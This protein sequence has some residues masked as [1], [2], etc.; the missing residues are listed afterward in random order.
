[1]PRIPKQPP[2]PAEEQKH[3]RGF[4]INKPLSEATTKDFSFIHRTDRA[5]ANRSGSFEHLSDNISARPG[6]TRSVYDAYRPA[7]ATPQF[8]RETF[9]KCDLIYKKVGLIKNI[10]D[11]YSDF[12]SQGIRVCHPVPKIQRIGRTWFK[13]VKGKER[14]ERFLNY[15]YRQGNTVIRIHTGKV[16]SSIINKMSKITAEDDGEVIEMPKRERNVI[17][18]DYTF[19]NPA[20]VEPVGGNLAAFSGNKRYILNIPPMITSSVPVSKEIEAEFLAGLSDEMKVLVKKGGY[21][22]LPP[23]R[24]RVYSYKK[25]DWEAWA[26]PITYSVFDNV[27][28][29]EKLRLADNAALDGLISQLR[30]FKLGDRA[31]RVAPTQ[32]AAN[33]LDSMLQTNVGGGTKEIIWGPDI[34]V[35][36]SNTDIHNFLGSEK[37]K[38]TLSAIFQAFGIPPTLT[39]DFGA[40]GTTNNYISLKACI[41]RIKY[42]RDILVSF[43]EEQLEWLRKSLGLAKPFTIEFDILNLVDDIAEKNLYLQLVDRNIVSAEVLQYLFNQ[44]PEMENVRLK[45]E[46]KGRKNH[47]LV[48]KASPLSSPED[49]RTEIALQQGSISPTEADL[50]PAEKTDKSLLDIQAQNAKLKTTQGGNPPKTKKRPGQG[51]P[52]NKQDSTKRKTRTFTA[53]LIPWLSQTQEKVTSIVSGMMLK[54]TGKKNLRCLT[55]EEKEKCEQ[56]SFLTLMAIPPDGVVDDAVVENALSGDFNM[57]ALASYEEQVKQYSVVNSKEPTVEEQRLIQLGVYLRY[58]TIVESGL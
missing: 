51:R 10:I 48:P 52:V 58:S 32:E 54:S 40:N 55:A 27:V 29:L 50:V 22:A 19:L 17:P 35:W 1:M 4:A 24:T 46:Y 20:T 47:K 36:E 30:I 2:S 42:G 45:R 12:G 14:S 23:D 26:L 57:E 31:E 3:P 5:E 38:P 8:Y 39:G 53:D 9:L 7:E 25:D 33:L 34:E 15:L 16:S 21:Y 43:W 28:T 13:K 49:K 56:L 18:L 11:L 41:Q 37:Y 6:F 44:D